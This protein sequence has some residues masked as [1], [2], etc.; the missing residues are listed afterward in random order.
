MDRELLIELRKP[1]LEDYLRWI[2]RCT[3][4]GPITVKRNN[5]VGRYIWS[6]FDTK[7][8]PVQHQFKTEPTKLIIPV[9]PYKISQSNY[10]YFKPFKMA[11]VNNYIDAMFIIDFREFVLNGVEKGVQRKYLYE[12][13]MNIKKFSPSDDLFERIKKKDYRR[14]KQIEAYMTEGLKSIGYN[15]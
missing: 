15:Q 3:K 11:Q 6:M 8:L 9:D 7:H 12:A 10:L 1:I 5:P 13:F 2:F 4:E 14:R